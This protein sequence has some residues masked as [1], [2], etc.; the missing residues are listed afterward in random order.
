M[1]GEICLGNTMISKAI[2]DNSTH[3]NFKKANQIAQAS[4]RRVQ[5]VVFLKKIIILWLLFN[6]I[7]LKIRLYFP[8]GRVYGSLPRPLAFVFL[9][10]SSGVSRELLNLPSVRNIWVFT[11]FLGLHSLSCSKHEAYRVRISMPSSVRTVTLTAR[12]VFFLRR[13]VSTSQ[14]FCHGRFGSPTFPNFKPAFAC[15][16]GCFCSE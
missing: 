5:F 2:L 6:D 4:T 3:K 10:K 11:L 15:F 7:H 9:L 13:P 16:L 1:Y 14:Y 12:E 8:I